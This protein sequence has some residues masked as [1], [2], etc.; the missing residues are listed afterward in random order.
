[1]AMCT[2]KSGRATTGKKKLRKRT[3]PAAMEAVE[4][5]RPTI[6]CIQPNVK[7]QSGTEA[8]AKIGIF[9]A[10]F[11]DGGAKFREGQRAKNG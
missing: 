8:A 9:A 5:G 7:P 1:M 11:G 10:S 4:A 3:S 2:V 6:E